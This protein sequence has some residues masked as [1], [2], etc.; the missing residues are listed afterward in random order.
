[1]G[2][3]ASQKVVSIQDFECWFELISD[4]I[5]LICILGTVAYLLW[6]RLKSNRESQLN[7]RIVFQ[8]VLMTSQAMLF[9]TKDAWK[10][11]NEV[12]LTDREKVDPWI[13][14]AY[15]LASQIFM[16]QHV[17]FIG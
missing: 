15:I 8:L 16:M 13:W 9:L 7:L 4:T 14:F 6:Q 12:L 10:I 1:M 11:K 3:T 2:T 17:L 5:E